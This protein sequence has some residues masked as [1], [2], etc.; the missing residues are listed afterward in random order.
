MV[1]RLRLTLGLV[2]TALVVGPVTL[3]RSAVPMT[4]SV[5]TPLKSFATSSIPSRRT[6]P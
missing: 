1:G 2:F 3:I 6:S 4:T 5:K